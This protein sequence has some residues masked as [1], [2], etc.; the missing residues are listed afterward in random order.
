[1]RLCH[2]PQPH[3]ELWVQKE[4]QQRILKD[5]SPCL[6][7][8]LHTHTDY[9]P[10]TAEEQL[11]NYLRFAMGNSIRWRKNILRFTYGDN[12]YKRTRI[13]RHPV[14]QDGD[15]YSLVNKAETYQ[16]EVV[17]APGHTYL[18]AGGKPIIGIHW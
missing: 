8:F 6:I 7:A 3:R 18:V 9:V 1:M 16:A 11:P 15:G 10:Y 14:V 17:M 5:L 4:M 13:R 2:H 12:I